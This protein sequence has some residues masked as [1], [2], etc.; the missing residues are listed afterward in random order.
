MDHSSVKSEPGD[1][2]R[3]V[4]K[5]EWI[6]KVRSSLS[7]SRVA[8]GGAERDGSSRVP[9][10][11]SLGPPCYP[12]SGVDPKVMRKDSSPIS[13]SSSH[14]SDRLPPLPT[15]HPTQNSSRRSSRSRS[16]HSR[17][18]ASGVAVD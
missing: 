11:L 10:L 13:S 16:S 2:R 17:T 14:N 6:E 7:V 5:M 8:P 9:R 3:K 1:P 18:D 4:F 15:E 12:E